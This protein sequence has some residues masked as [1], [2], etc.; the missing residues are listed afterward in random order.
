MREEI[1]YEVLLDLWNSY[2]ALDWEWC[3][4]IL[5]AYR[6]SLWTERLLWIY[7]EEITI[8]SRA[9]PYYSAPFNGSRGVTQGDLLPPNIFNMVVDVVIL[10][11]VVV[12]FG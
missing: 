1:L 12:V 9:G 8:V 2:D 5:V 11:W 4:E 7:W 3:M 10:H 6:F